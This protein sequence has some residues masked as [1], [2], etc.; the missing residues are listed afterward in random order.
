MHELKLLSL[1]HHV[2]DVVYPR[3]ELAFTSHSWSAVQTDHN[4]DQ[5]TCRYSHIRSMDVTRRIYGIRYA[6]CLPDFE[7]CSS[8][9]QLMRGYTLC[10]GPFLCRIQIKETSRR[11]LTLQSFEDGLS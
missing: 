1:K 2:L 7:R 11:G 3:G 10:D 9:P 4:H 6:S 8:C 5:S